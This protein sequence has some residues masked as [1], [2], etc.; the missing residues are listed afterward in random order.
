MNFS[1]SLRAARAE[2]IPLVPMLA[3]DLG[4]HPGVIR[5]HLEQAFAR[6]SPDAHLVPWLDWMKTERST[7]AGF[8]IREQIGHLVE[9][10]GRDARFKYFCH[11]RGGRRSLPA[12]LQDFHATQEQGALYVQRT[13]S[14]GA[15]AEH[16]W[17]GKADFRY[18][19]LGQL[20]RFV[21]F[22]RSPVSEESQSIRNA[23]RT[24]A[25]KS[26]LRAYLPAIDG[27]EDA[28]KEEKVRA[29]H[30]MAP[31]ITGVASFHVL[32]LLATKRAPVELQFNRDDDGRYSFRLDTS[33]VRAMRT[34]LYDAKLKCPAHTPPR[35]PESPEDRVATSLQNMFHAALTKAGEYD[36]YTDS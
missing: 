3:P 21:L 1:G 10:E 7:I 35:D 26:A 24:V 36:I 5:D 25:M 8:L 31:S 30:D 12:F 16:A 27:I 20:T 19:V 15:D 22:G 33:L 23:L 14:Y 2:V 32:E 13:F 17:W 29:S 18:F 4:R 6:N 34:R 28:K 9:G 11:R